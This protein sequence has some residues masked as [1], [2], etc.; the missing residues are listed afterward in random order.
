M[1]PR[2][3]TEVRLGPQGPQELTGAPARDVV[4]TVERIGAHGVQRRSWDW[5]E[6][7]LCDVS[8]SLR[9]GRNRVK[10]T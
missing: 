3:P 4:G 7:T 6:P 9:F 1:C 2:S 5:P 8:A 10:R